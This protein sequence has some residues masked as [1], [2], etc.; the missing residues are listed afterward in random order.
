[1]PFG[2]GRKFL[3]NANK[4]TDILIGGW[5]AS[6]LYIFN[7]GRPWQLPGNVDVVDPDYY[8]VDRNR[9]VNG[10]QFFQGV[11]PCVAQYG[12]DTT[13]ADGYKRDA[14]GRLVPELL[15]YSVAAGCTAPSFIIRE[16]FTTR[17]TAI[18]DYRVRRPSYEQLD[19]NFSKTFR[20]TEKF[21]FQFRAEAYN[22]LNTPQYDERAYNTT[23][24]DPE[25]GSINKNNVRQSNFPRFWQLGFKLLF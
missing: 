23:P 13:K 10:V 8:K 21:R 17:T 7:S 11:R 24:T 18:R 14:Q 19:L 25:F 20:L 2:K 16:P 6:G 5:Q 4:L 1:M 9:S 15:A 12:R 22:L 3:G